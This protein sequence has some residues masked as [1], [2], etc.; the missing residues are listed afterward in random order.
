M[1]TK[2]EFIRKKACVKYAKEEFIGIIINETKNTITIQTSRGKK[3]LLKLNS[4]INI[5]NQK[6]L[7]KDIIKR[8]EDRIKK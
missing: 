3:K 4:I 5:N 1:I 8:P 6:I 7:G 2:S